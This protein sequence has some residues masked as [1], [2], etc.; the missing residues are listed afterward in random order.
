MTDDDQKRSLADELVRVFKRLAEGDLSARV[1]RNF[2][3]DSEDAVA[4][5]VGVFAEQLAERYRKYREYEA[6]VAG[7]IEKF[8]AVAAGDFEV[9]AERTYHGDAVDTLAYLLNN[10]ASE[11]GELVGAHDRQRMLLETVIESMLDG[12]LMLDPGGRIT[13]SN[14]AMADLLRRTTD[15]LVGM[16]LSDVLAVPEHE[17]AEELALHLTRGVFRNRDTLFR[18]KDGSALTIALNASPHR[19][20]Q[21]ALVGIVL[22]ARDDREL[23]SARADLERSDRLATMG[24]LAAG[25]AHEINNPLAFVSANVDFVLEELEECG[26][27]GTLSPERIA[28]IVKALRSS[29]T[30]TARVR[31]I[32]REL[33]GFARTAPETV[34]PVDVNALVDTALGFVGNE[35]RHHARLTKAYGTPPPVLANE[36]RLVQAFLNLLQNA[37]QSIPIGAADQNEI[38]VVTG[39]AEGAAYVEVHDTGCGIAEENLSRVFDLFYTTKPVGIGVGLGLSIALRLI[40]KAGGR[41]EVSSRVGAGSSFRVVLPVAPPAP[42][43]AT[44]PAKSR[45]RKKR[46]LDILVVD[47][48]VEVGKS[49]HRILQREHRVDVTSSALDALAKLQARSYDLILCDLLM[50]EMTGMDLYARVAASSPEMAGR[51]VFMTGS[52]FGAHAHDFLGRSSNPSFEKPFDARSLRAVVAKVRKRA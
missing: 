26:A 6:A 16:Q 29:R 43:T 3:R 25:V 2:K 12:V 47:D 39:V 41:L 52:A 34:S 13:H 1:P 18:T 11:V 4:F 37:A 49:V 23:K 35:I 14:R 9:R 31:N 50:P 24:M 15:E 48:E 22:V 32:V 44:M 45:P 42:A 17:L 8:I 10:V 7:L 20:V 27:S 40:E 51:M 33:R 19:D 21:G 28:E 46:S 5:F 30:G 36:G 38:R